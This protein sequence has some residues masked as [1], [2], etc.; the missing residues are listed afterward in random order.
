MAHGS[1][2]MLIALM[3]DV[4]TCGSYARKAILHALY[5]MHVVAIAWVLPMCASATTMLHGNNQAPCQRH[6]AMHACD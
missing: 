4:F 6:V 5:M 2:C 1:M 3:H